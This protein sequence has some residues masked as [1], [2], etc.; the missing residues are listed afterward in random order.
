[1]N[2]LSW[3]GHAIMAVGMMCLY[4][5]SY[6]QLCRDYHQVCHKLAVACAVVKLLGLAKYW[7]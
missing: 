2:N 3:L 1:M 4:L 5:S 7:C 6:V